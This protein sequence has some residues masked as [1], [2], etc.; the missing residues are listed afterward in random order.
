MKLTESQIATAKANGLALATVHG[1]IRRGMDPDKA[2]HAAP[3]D[4]AA[5]GRKNSRKPGHQW[6]GRFAG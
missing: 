2:V 6:R 5:G 1:R 4:P 3:A